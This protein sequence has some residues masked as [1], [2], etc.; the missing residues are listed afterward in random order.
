[1]EL[2]ALLAPIRRRLADIV[3][4]AVV[5]LVDDTTQMQVVQL[6]VLLDTDT[7]DAVEHFQPYGFTAVPLKGAE[8]ILLSLGGLRGHPIAI[9]IDDRRHR[10][11]GLQPGESAIYNHQG[12]FIL[13]GKDGHITIHAAADVTIDAPTTHCAGH[14]TVD[15]NLQVDGSDGI[16]ATNGDVSAGTIS[17]KNHR[18]SG[19]QAGGG[20]SGPPI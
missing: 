15:G 10:K 2:T 19:V 8:S 14:L 9:M 17:L 20:A 11:T 13:I 18:H 1:M 5:S 6:N 12:D 16:F 3:R 7:I 4:R